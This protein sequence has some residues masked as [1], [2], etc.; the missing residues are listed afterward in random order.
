MSDREAP[1]Q[2]I[3]P[4]KREAWVQLLKEAAQRAHAAEEDA[5]EARFY[6]N[7]VIKSAHKTGMFSMREIGRYVG[8]S[9]R[10]VWL[11]ITNSR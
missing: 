10:T 4:L 8:L 5:R 11:H 3:M 7:E 1:P 2:P 9:G 6:R